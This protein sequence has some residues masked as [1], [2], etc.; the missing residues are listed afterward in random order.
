M[1]YPSIPRPS[2]PN[3]RLTDWH[4]Q[5][6]LHNDEQIRRHNNIVNYTV[7][8]LHSIQRSALLEPNAELGK[9]TQDIQTYLFKP[10]PHKSGSL[11][12][13]WTRTSPAH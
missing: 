7:S 6:F 12:F 11:L 2:C 4:I 3:Q 5:V 13:D 8:L 1:T 9:S 10:N